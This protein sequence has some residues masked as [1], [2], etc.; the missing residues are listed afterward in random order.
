METKIHIRKGKLYEKG[1]ALINAAFEYW[2]E[3]QKV[4]KRAAVVWLKDTS[5]HMVLFTRGEYLQ[6]I[7]QN[8][9]ILDT[10]APLEEPFEVD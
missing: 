8:V 2:Q 5:G 1:Q 4:S 3:Y 7:M 10:E 6:T 9:D